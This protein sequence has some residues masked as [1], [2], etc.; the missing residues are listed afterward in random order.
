MRVVD[1]GCGNAYLTLGAYAYLSD[2]RGREVELVGVDVR[3]QARARNTAI[4]E[5]LGWSDH[6]SFV[7]GTIDAAD[8]AAPD[9]VLA[10]H[11][12]DTAT[13]DALVR[14]VRWEAPIVLAAPCCHHRN[15]TGTRPID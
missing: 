9:V 15:P 14:A 11:A 12:C 5:S 7:A 8:V 1:L 3:E 10:L 6:V 4:A 2:V 13:D